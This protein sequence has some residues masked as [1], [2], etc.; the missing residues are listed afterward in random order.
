MPNARSALDILEQFGWPFPSDCFHL[1][2]AFLRE[3]FELGERCAG[4]LAALLGLRGQSIALIKGEPKHQLK[5][6]GSHSCG[7][8]FEQFSHCIMCA[9][10]VCEC[11]Y[12][13]SYDQ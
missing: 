2:F 13:Q 10:S 12:V 6:M 11:V 7:G 5:S 9:E 8:Y 4:W 3:L 1:D